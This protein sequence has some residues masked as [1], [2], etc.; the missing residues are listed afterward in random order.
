[1]CCLQAPSGKQVEERRQLQAAQQAV[2]R[3]ELAELEDEISWRTSEINKLRHTA[4]RLPPGTAT[5]FIL[6]SRIAELLPVYC[7]CCLDSV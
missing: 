5:R 2:R 6:E 3:R 4:D 1:M 7:S